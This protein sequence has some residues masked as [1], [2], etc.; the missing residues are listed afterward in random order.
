MTLRD[1]E[2]RIFVG[3]SLQRQSFLV[4]FFFVLNSSGGPL[5]IQH[6]LSCMVQYSTF[7]IRYGTFSYIVLSM[8]V[9]PIIEAG[10]E[11][12]QTLAREIS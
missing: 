5:N 2:Q 7:P 11:K 12:G 1:S 8:S 10:F 6:S 9:L 4:R 3:Q